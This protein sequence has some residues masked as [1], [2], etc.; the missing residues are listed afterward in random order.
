MSSYWKS[1]DKIKVS[2]TQVSVP[3]TN[4]LS[5]SSTAGQTGRR[6]DFQ[7]PP[8]VKF[9]DG[10]NSYLQF[11]IK[12]APP[13]GRSPTRLHLD[14]FIGGQ[15][16]VKNLRI[17][18]GN[19]SVLLEE[20]SDYNAKV[21]MQY[22]YNQDDSMRKMRAIKEGS[23]TSTVENRGTLGT[24][25]SNNIDT[26]SNPY[27]RPIGTVPAGRDFNSTDFLTAKLSLPIHC[28]LFADGGNK[29]FPVLMTDGLFIE[30]DLEDPARY[31]KQ[32]DS[33]NR[34]RRVKQN[35]VFHGVDVGG[36]ALAINNATN[37]SEIF[38]GLQNNMMSVENCPFVKGERIGIC[39]ATNPKQECALTL[40]ANGGQGYPKINNIERDASG[41]IK[42]TCEEFQNSNTGTGV[43]ATSNNFILFSAA[44]DNSN[45]VQVGDLTTPI[46]IPE[47]GGGFATY[48][49]TSVISNAEIVCQK[50]E[51]DPQYEAGM[52]KRMR[53][54]GSIEIDIP[55][56]TN[57]KHSLLKTNRNA[58]V[59]IP[60][61][62]TRAKSMIV[63]PTDAS[64]LSTPQLIGGLEQ[65]YEEE[66]TAMDGELHSI[67]T[68]Q[69]GII[70]RLTSYQ[71]V[72]DDKLVPSR[73]IV[74][75]KINKGVSISAQ[76]LIEL[77]KALNQ[78]GV[79]PRSF[80]DYNRN[81]LIGRAYALNDGVAN[82]NNKSNQL[83]LFYNETTVAGAD[84]P[85]EKDKL[86]F[87]F[88]FH[89]RRISIKGDSVTVSL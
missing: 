64:T 82:L 55:S 12:L 14:P 8:T 9:L 88:V 53:D 63:M 44:C 74:V 47:D 1:E 45:R 87:C 50:V 66:V 77:E 59:N 21:Q 20:I 43:E 36:T 52:M 75:S 71:M 38:L 2:Q 18:S 35:P 29:I 65:T 84:Q 51:V 39:S 7:I 27:Y 3:S 69:C 25:V 28:G 30:V 79:V 72:V 80:V 37:R 26:S 40:T 56:V 32:L 58:T 76:P 13:A 11:D 86:L 22:S 68:G 24:S 78:A 81:F 73:P 42:I 54:G 46:V 10:K 57:Y 31:I 34:H 48:N 4:G 6:V 89:L 83:Q 5:Y 41:K 60:V 85:P 17:Y 15:S 49:P 70:D 33:V 61:S 67:R 16:V 62:N 19:R 23:L